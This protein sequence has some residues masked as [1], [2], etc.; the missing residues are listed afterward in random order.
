[1]IDV[2]P[3]LETV[4][5]Q[6]CTG[7]Q[8]AEPVYARLC[9]EIGQ[10]PTF[11]RK[12]WEYVF[13][14]RALEQMGMLHPGR[15]GVGFG[16]G[17]E[18][19]AAVMAK[20][21]ARVTCTDL[22]PDQYSDKYWGT[23]SVRDYFYEGILPWPEFERLVDF[24]EVDMNAIPDDLGSH[25]FIWS[26][27]ALEHLGSLRHG[28][29]F[30]VNANKCLRPGGVAVHTTEFNVNSNEDTFESPGLSIY[31]RRDILEIQSFLEHQGY[32]VLPVNFD[33]GD[34]PIDRHIDLPP[35]SRDKHLKLLHLD[36]Y[37]VTSLALVIVKR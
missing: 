7:S 31:R 28:A 36:R 27:C 12:Q 13:I 9:R 19:L 16:C 17:K 33:V 24:R 30:I 23:D 32:F 25:D 4:T 1:M 18:P 21:G 20:R 26:S 15:T 34:A 29:D 5:S 6:L 2:S 11:H 35:Y 37:V 8:F 22:R 10:T 3:T 14:L